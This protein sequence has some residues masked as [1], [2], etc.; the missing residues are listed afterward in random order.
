MTPIE[1]HQRA[2]ELLSQINLTK[3]YIANYHG[4]LQKFDHYDNLRSKTQHKIEIQ[5]MVL[6]RLEQRYSRL[7]Q[8]I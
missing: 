2:I 6:A 8:S 1:K 4:Y 5:K 3:Q 7:I